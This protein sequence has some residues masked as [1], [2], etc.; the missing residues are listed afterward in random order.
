MI[1]LLRELLLARIYFS[2]LRRAAAFFGQSA[3]CRKVAYR[4]RGGKVFPALRDAP[5]I[6][7]DSK[8]DVIP[9]RLDSADG[10]QCTTLAEWV[11]AVLSLT[12]LYPV[13]QSDRL[14][15]GEEIAQ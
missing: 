10:R 9:H 8:A 4:K 7:L 11:V 13:L 6:R 1:V 5:E 12:I 3:A 14:A 15:S 2:I